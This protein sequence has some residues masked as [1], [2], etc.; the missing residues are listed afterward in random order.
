M[1]PTDPVEAT[2]APDPPPGPVGLPPPP[3]PHAT[4]AASAA[5]TT[6]CLPLPIV[7]TTPPLGS[8]EFSG[9]VEPD[10]PL[11]FARGARA[12]ELAERG[13]PAVGE[14]Q[15]K[16]VAARAP[17]DRDAALADARVVAR[18]PRRHF[19]EQVQ[20]PPDAEPRAE[21][22]HQRVVVG[23]RRVQRVRVRHPDGL[24]VD[25]GERGDL[26]RRHRADD[27]APLG[28]H[29]V[30]PLDAHDCVEAQTSPVPLAEE[31]VLREDLNRAIARAVDADLRA[32]HQAVTKLQADLRATVE[33][34]PVGE[35][36]AEA[37]CPSEG[38][39]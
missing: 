20:P 29:V 14:V 23:A 16:Q 35:Q 27:A 7:S 4:N 19:A 34:E 21:P 12:R 30:L 17:F 10:V 22:Q 15:L 32:R 28:A 6:S 24:R 8:E 39:K 25:G 33:P 36:V 5:A 9:D 26:L 3:P 18:E 2:S 11:V 1:P 31:A 37:P 38:V 13:P